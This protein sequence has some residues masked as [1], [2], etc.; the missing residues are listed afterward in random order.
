MR[1][2]WVPRVKL[3]HPDST[4]VS[5]LIKECHKTKTDWIFEG[6]VLAFD[7]AFTTLEL[8]RNLTNSGIC[9]VSTYMTNRL[10]MQEVGI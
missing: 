5:S 7:R 3:S 6:A 9:F 4:V 2:F 10:G 8:A 1:F